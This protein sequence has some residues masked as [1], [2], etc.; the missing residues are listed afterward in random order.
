MALSDQ[1]IKSLLEKAERAWDSWCYAPIEHNIRYPEEALEAYNQIIKN[2]PPHPHYFMKRARIKSAL[3]SW[4]DGY[5]EGAVEDMNRAMGIEK[6]IPD[7]A[8]YWQA[9]GD[10]LVNLNRYEEALNAYE[11]TIELKPDCAEAWKNKGDI[12]KKK[13]GR[14]QE[15]YDAYYKAAEYYFESMT[16]GSFSRRNMDLRDCYNEIIETY[17]FHIGVK[18]EDRKLQ[19]ELNAGNVSNELREF[20]KENKYSLS[21]R[22]KVEQIDKKLIEI[23][24]IKDEDKVYT[25][26]DQPFSGLYIYI[27]NDPPHPYH[28]MRRAIF[29]GDAIDMPSKAIEDISRAIELDPGQGEY[30]RYRGAWLLKNLWKNRNN[31]LYNADDKLVYEKVIADYKTAVEKNPTDPEIW[32]KLMELNILLHN[33]DDAIVIYGS[34]RP[35]IQTNEDQLI[36]VWLGCTALALAGDTIEEKDKNPLYDQTIRI[37]LTSSI[38][39]ITSKSFIDKIRSEEKYKAKWQKAIEIY[40][41]FSEHLDDWEDRGDILGRLE[42]Y[43]D[44]LLAYKRAIELTPDR[45]KWIW[46][47]KGDIFSSLK[48]YEEAIQSYT[49]AIELGRSD[50]YRLWD[51]KAGLLSLMNR[52]EEA[53]DALV[54][55]EELNKGFFD[56]C[57]IWVQKGAC[58]EKLN[59]YEEALQVY[60]KAIK[61]ISI[62]DDEWENAWRCKAAILEKL[63]KHDDARQVYDEAK[64]LRSDKAKK[65]YELARESALKGAISDVRWRLSNAIRLDAKYKDLARNDDSFKSLRDNEDFKKIVE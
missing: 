1:E 32:L 23:W 35:F 39:R 41:L 26:H 33:W 36:R 44:A 31:P 34:C 52:Y 19:T 4:R 30:Y 60:D 10:T 40:K 25:I 49:A 7:D 51:K 61:A 50:P 28:Y 56:Y 8:S 3:A 53:I 9:K 17:I 11:K 5:S 54:K 59:R 55:V 20:F 37:K 57:S 21:E 47:K 2:M 22:V 48:R 42:C 24:R 46:E 58:L 27:E 6:A 43:E 29:W 14:Y 38:S 45:G 13:F 15:S 62:G 63:G 18:Y 12:L 16:D 65:W 64:N